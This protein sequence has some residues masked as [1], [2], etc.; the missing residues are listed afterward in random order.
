MSSKLLNKNRSDRLAFQIYN[1]ILAFVH[2][3]GIARTEKI[4]AL[5][6]SENLGVSR[7]PVSFVLF[8]ME[9]EG[10]IQGE[11]KGGWI[12][13]PITIDD[14]DEIFDLKEKLFPMIVELAT[15][16]ITPDNNAKLFIFIDEIN[17]AL[18]RN[19]LASWRSADKGFNRVLE[20]SAGN[21]RLG[22]FEQIL[23]NQ[24][25]RLLTTYLSL[26]SSNKDIFYLNKEIA[27]AISLGN[28]SLA[29]E[30]AL[31]YV[32]NLRENLRIFL[33]EL[34]IPLLGTDV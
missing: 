13:S 7:T 14:L 28:T 12:V 17:R 18:K 31:S 25:Y 33:K 23:D 27:L 19:D 20:I 11:E 16:N 10:L 29:K 24:L 22:N 15:R 32:N 8:R 30:K 26:P 34:L 6:I 9:L 5:N 3:R 1:Q 21:F 2:D 4:S